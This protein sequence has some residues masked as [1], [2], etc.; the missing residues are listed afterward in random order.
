MKEITLTLKFVC[1][2]VE[3]AEKFSSEAYH[4][5]FTTE[6]YPRMILSTIHEDGIPVF[7]TRNVRLS[8]TP[9]TFT[10][11]IINELNNQI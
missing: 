2:D 6:D 5:F 1:K 9:T 8:E 7:E 4:T 11:E 3:Q 10:E